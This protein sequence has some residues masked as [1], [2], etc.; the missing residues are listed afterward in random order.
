MSKQ[1]PYGAWASPITSDM[2][3]SKAIRLGAGIFDG[4]DIYWMEGRPQEQGRSVIVKRT[5]DGETT[6]V[7]PSPFNARTRVHEYGGRSF[8]VDNGIVYFSDFADQRLYRVTPGKAPTP[9]TPESEAKLRYADGIVDH[10]RQRIICV[11]EDHRGGGEAVNTIA[12]IPFDGSSADADEQQVLV[13]GN[14]FYATPRISPDGQQLLWLT[15]HHPNMP[16]DG[17]ELWVGAIQTDGALADARHIA[18]GDRESIFQPSWAPDG[19]ITFV[20]DR[21]GWWNL[22]RW[23]EDHAECLAEM[24]AEFGLP[25]GVFGMATYDYRLDLKRR[26]LTPIDLPYT[27][28]GSPHAS[29]GGKVLLRVGAA[30]RPTTLILFDPATGATTTLR[31]AHELEVDPDYLSTPEPI[32]FPTTDG[33]TAY[34]L[35]YPPQNPD[36]EASEDAKPPLLVISHGGPTAATNSALDMSIQYWTSRGIAVLDV[37]YGGSTGYGRAYRERLNEQWG[38]VDV[39]DCVNGAHYLVEQGRVDGDRLAIRGGSAGG[40]TTLSALA[41]CDVFHAGAS[42]YG[43]SDLE[44]LATDTHKFESRYLDNLIG[45]YPETR[46]RYVARSPIHHI[47]GLSC[48]IIFFQGL[49]DAVVPPPQAEQMVDALREKGIPVAY[50]PFEGEQHGFR[51][52]EHIKRA[53]DAELYFYGQIFGF[54]PAD[55][56]EP[57]TIENLDTAES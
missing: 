1:A 35:F 31:K 30:D 15:W 38:I 45:P 28:I 23:Q 12:A 17:T 8:L 33:K 4:Q 20:S 29:E 43:V 48:P 24:A 25:Q 34:A 32:E 42:Y 47:E 39:D 5:P 7:N 16:W 9:I 44:A 6:D 54:E 3:V 13:A 37:N 49:E 19:A 52:A 50:L 11:R 46:A 2:L 51:R 40:Y 22:Y 57:V 56:I 53:I 10:H 27:N 21:S 41:F 55:E 36:Y 26:K 18:G 14:D